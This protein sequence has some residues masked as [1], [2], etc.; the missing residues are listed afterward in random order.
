[1]LIRSLLAAAAGLF[2][3][4]LL[5][6]HLWLGAL[7]WFGCGALLL[8]RARPRW[9]VVHLP[10][11]VLL[12]PWC[13]W[14]YAGRVQELT[15][16]Y[17]RGGPEALGLADLFAVFGLNL[18]M[19]FVGGVL[20]FSEVAVETA[21]L[22][23]PRGSELTFVAG[24][25]PRCVPKVSAQVERWRREARRGRKRFGPERLA[26]T[27]HAEGSSF[28][29][30]LA[31]TPATMTA[32]LHGQL[33]EVE[34]TVPIDYPER[35]AL[36]L[37]PLPGRPVVVEEGLFHALEERGWLHPYQLTYRSWVALDGPAPA[38]CEAWS[39]SA[40]DALGVL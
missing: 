27:Y 29:G 32:E 30:A 26:W 18:C 24:D 40:L 23:V 3:A 10:S 31:L 8:G 16:L 4:W 37:L 11:G 5:C 6:W 21:L 12:V 17:D 28:R 33:L 39:M 2:G 19:A 13:I 1:M 22:T 15:A 36:V 7:W 34:T 9:W 25:F 35:Y 20:G 38:T 14:R